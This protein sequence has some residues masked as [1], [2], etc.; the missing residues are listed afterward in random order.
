MFLIDMQKYQSPVRWRRLK[1]H[2]GLEMKW[3]H[4]KSAFGVLHRVSYATV[5]ARVAWEEKRKIVGVVE[6]RKFASKNIHFYWT[7]A[8][9]IEIFDQIAGVAA[10]DSIQL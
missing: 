7:N 6:R 5:W 3:C 1:Y 9:T 8:A 10:F 4:S 2:V